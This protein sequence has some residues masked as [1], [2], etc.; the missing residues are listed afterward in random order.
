MHSLVLCDFI[1][2]VSLFSPTSSVA[3][4]DQ[5]RHRG[6]LHQPIRATK[7]FF[8]HDS[9]HC[10]RDRPLARKLRLPRE[11]PPCRRQCHSPR[12]QTGETTRVSESRNRPHLPRTHH[13]DRRDICVPTAQDARSAETLS[14]V[15]R[16]A[17][18]WRGDPVNDE[19]PVALDGKTQK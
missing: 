6:P 15:R 4:A 12:P 11:R 1:C 3:R 19:S 16:S 17:H 9:G 18:W 13:R 5:P 14:C 2:K 7:K 8:S 10:R